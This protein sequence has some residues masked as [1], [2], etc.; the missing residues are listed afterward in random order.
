MAEGV[1]HFFEGWVVFLACAILLA[2][3][4]YL[5]AWMSGKAFFEVFYFPNIT[6]KP[7]RGYTTKSAG[8]GPIVVC[9]L[10]LCASGLAVF[11]I[12]GR[13]EIIPERTRFVEFP[14]RIGQ[15]QGHASL[16]DSET[17]KF[18]GLDDYVLS[19]YSRA[20]GKVVNLYIAYYASQRKGESPIRRS[21]AFPAGAGL[22]PASNR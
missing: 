7:P 4:M 5:L 13:S 8:E 17:E 15:W 3:E 2:G 10:L 21:C 11:F 9:L 14:A 12:S 20:D 1:L 22:L 19:D 16:L 6:V 18:L